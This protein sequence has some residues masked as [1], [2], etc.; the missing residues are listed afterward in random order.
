M[1]PVVQLVLNCG[2]WALLGAVLA[3]VSACSSGSKLQQPSELSPVVNL[4][5][6]KQAW[7][8]NVGEIAF[9]LHVQA[10]GQTV[11]VAASNG[12]V[13]VLDASE[14]TTLWRASVG[15]PLAAG[16]GHDGRLTAV[17]T[18][19]N[20]LVALA[21]GT[22][23]WRQ[24]LTAQSYTA[25]F[26]AGERVFVLGADRSVSAYD[27]QSGRRLWSQQRTGEA[28]VLR[29]PGVML[30][31]GDTLVVGLSGKLLGLSP[32]NGSVRWEAPVA[33][34]RGTNDVERLVDLVAPANRQGNM[35][36]ARAFQAAV[37]C[38]DAARGALLWSKAATGTVG[39][40]GDDRFVFGVEADSTLLA[41]R[42]TDGE[43]AWAVEQLRYRKLSAPLVIGRSVVV[44]DG[45]GLLHFFSREDGSPL[46]RL[47]TD[48]SPIVA[49]PVLA[50]N[51]LVVVT[52]QGNIFGFK[53]E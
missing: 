2:K 12:T 33:S 43:R 49:A 21:S 13:A 31:V 7:S 20:E 9:P 47:S 44:G 15:A 38:V 4:I 22:E 5:A 28:L 6:V 18:T 45:G 42:R 3:T 37:G 34:P 14:G 52:R 17:I 11:A 29:Q 53:P 16:V 48:G 30:A 39:V 25:P 50:G 32:L 40:H 46:T 24:Q 35:V 27:G 19:H 1:K 36:C 26:V 41:W 23:L 10:A 8:A 51:T